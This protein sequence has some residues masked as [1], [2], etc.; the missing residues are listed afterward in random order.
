MNSCAEPVKRSLDAVF[1]QCQQ[2]CQQGLVT[3]E[4]CKW[5]PHLSLLALVSGCPH[6]DYPLASALAQRCYSVGN[7]DDRHQTGQMLPPTRKG[8]QV[9]RSTVGR[10]GPSYVSGLGSH[11]NDNGLLSCP[12]ALWDSGLLVILFHSTLCFSFRAPS[13]NCNQNEL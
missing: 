1:A 9:E 5:K 7:F 2:C 3:P 13:T 11:V 12:L 6:S 4:R 10:G 8:G